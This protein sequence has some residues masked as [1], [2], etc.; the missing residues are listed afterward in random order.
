MLKKNRVGALVASLVVAASLATGAGVASASS[1][2]VV[3]AG[4]SP[5]TSARPAATR[6]V[7]LTASAKQVEEGDRLTLTATI[8]S[9]QQATRVTLQ[10]ASVSVFSGNT[11]WNPVKT[12]GVR[13]KRKVPLKV[14]ATDENTERYRAVVTYK[15]MKPA[16]SKPVKVAVW[17]W[18]P[19]S[20]YDPYYET[21]GAIF[22]TLTLNGHPYTGWGAATY[23][24]VGAWESRFTPGRNCTTFRGVIG[25][26]DISH[27]GSSGL[28]KFTAE[29]TVIYESPVLTPGMDVSVNLPLA[30]PY[31]FG[32]QLFDT[33]PGGTTGRDAVQA[34]PVIGDPA[35]LCTGV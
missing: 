13:G 11:Y 1:T 5:D 28:I 31:R 3:D 22:G 19:L 4:S 30:Q 6:A 15:T 12:V 24:H 8:K 14:V 20:E 21:G 17:R 29:D 18:V 23:S 25:I 32:I 33:T 7:R 35:L 9:P 2:D 26:A 16:T 34:W 10:K 27:D